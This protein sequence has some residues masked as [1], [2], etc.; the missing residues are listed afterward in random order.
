MFSNIH[1]L[2]QPV[3]RLNLSW[4]EIGFNQQNAAVMMLCQLGT[5]IFGSSFC[6]CDL[7]NLELQCKKSGYPLMRT[8][9]DPKATC[10]VQ[11][12]YPHPIFPLSSALWLSLEGT[13]WM[14]CL[15]P[16]NPAKIPPDCW[17]SYSQPSTVWLTH[18]VTIMADNQTA[19][20]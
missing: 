10:I 6:F 11:E 18:R 12:A 2:V 8:R 17:P 5:H 14:S 15:E 9:R 16:S 4:S 7:G 3:S 13:R 19:V 1:T 20:I